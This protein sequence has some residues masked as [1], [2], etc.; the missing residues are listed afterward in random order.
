[1]GWSIVA[2]PTG[3]PLSEVCGASS[4]S[5]ATPASALAHRKVTLPPTRAASLAKPTASRVTSNGSI[6]NLIVG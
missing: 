6:I 2:E 1:V 5:A 4:N 3:S